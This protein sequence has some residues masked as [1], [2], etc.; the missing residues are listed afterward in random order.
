MKIFLGAVIAGAIGIFVWLFG[1]ALLH[2]TVIGWTGG[3]YIL[4]PLIAIALLIIGA[5]LL[6]G[7]AKGMA[8]VG[9]LA[10]VVLSVISWV[11]YDFDMKSV[12][13]N[14]A[15]VT[16]SAA[17]DYAERAPYDV[18]RLSSKNN[19]GD[20]TG[21]AHGVKSLADEKEHGVWNSLVQRRGWMTGYESIQSNDVP[22]YGEVSASN[23]TTCDFNTAVAGQ[24]MGGVFPHESLDYRVLGATPGNVTFDDGDAYGY[25]DKHEAPIVVMPLKQLN[26][27]WTPSWSPFGAALYNGATGELTVVTDTSKVPGPVY[28]QSLAKM[29]RESLTAIGNWGDYWNQRAG[30]ED[31]AGD[32]GDP[33]EGNTSEFTMR[34]LGDD[35]SDYV[36]P[37]TP[38]GD[39]SSVIALAS[40]EASTAKFGVRNVLTVHKYGKGEARAANSTI[41]KAVKSS[42]SWMPDWASGLKIFEIVPGADGQ[43]VA[44]IGQTQSVV[45]RAVIEADGSAVL[46]D[47]HGDEVVRS[48][49]SDS[50]DDEDAHGSTTPRPAADSDL[51]KL[52]PDQLRELADAVLDELTA[53]A[54]N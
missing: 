46:Y 51:T 28:P 13:A 45:Y 54:G 41:A 22:L 19:L 10:V 5:V 50:N 11:R 44:S 8:I 14:E 29:Q 36:T 35:D 43:W 33:N 12:Y 15:K 37:L 31:T 30:F 32:D 40:T 48:G 16:D 47:R 38:R 17:P 27:F 24:R 23:V 6:P 39:S 53:R 1:P 34:G 7:A 18:A 4:L 21:T 52:T 49:G 25:C 26:G 9:L 20:T 2:S 3:G 42:Y